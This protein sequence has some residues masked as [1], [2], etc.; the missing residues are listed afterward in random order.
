MLF[1]SFEFMFLFLPAAVAL[2]FLA[3]RS[4]IEA[5]VIVTSASSLFFYA[6]WNPKFV[7]LPV[8]SVAINLLLARVM[9]QGR[10][11]DAAILAAGIAANLAVLC[12]FKYSDFLLSVWQGTTPGPSNVPLAL[13]FTTFVQIAFLCDLYKDR[14]QVNGPR[15]GVFVTFFPH[16]IAGPIVRWNDLG[17]QIADKTRYRVDWGNVG[18]GLTIFTFGLAKKL[19]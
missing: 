16:L 19:R 12:Y 8:L 1:Y 11:Y 5:A 3:A 17:Y 18:I 6:W 15:Y 7:A 13:S 2:H 9:L 10:R 4:S 14:Q